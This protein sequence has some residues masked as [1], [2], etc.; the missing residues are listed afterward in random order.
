MKTMYQLYL[1]LLLHFFFL[2]SVFSWESI[3]FSYVV[4]AASY[5]PIS[6]LPSALITDYHI[7]KSI[8]LE[9]HISQHL[10]QIKIANKYKWK[11]LK[12]TSKK[13]LQ[14]G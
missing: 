2:I 7:L 10:L 4:E 13:A 11:L 6:I 14:G 5:L 9:N 12:E 1:S 8:N 3:E